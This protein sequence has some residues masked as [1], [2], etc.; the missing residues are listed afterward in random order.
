MPRM[1]CVLSDGREV[2]NGEE[3]TEEEYNALPECDKIFFS[4][5]EPTEEE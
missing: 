3:I 1:C 4:P 2:Y 5:C